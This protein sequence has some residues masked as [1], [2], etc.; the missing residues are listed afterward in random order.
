MTSR[1]SFLGASV[2]R[3]EDDRLL[4]GRGCY[5]ADI[6]LP[7]ML[8][9]AFV[10]SPI[11]HGRIAS[12]DTSTAEK[13]EGVLAARTAE[14]MTDVRPFPDFYEAARPIELFALARHKVRH[15]GA[16]VAVVVANSRYRAEDAAETIS[17]EFDPLPAVTS[18]QQALEPAAPKLFDKWSDNKL[19]SV[20]T[21]EAEVDTEFNRCRT[22]SGH[23]KIQRHSGVPMETRGVVAEYRDG[24]LTVWTSTQFPHIARTMLSYTLPIDE[25][26]IRVVVPDVGGGFGV[27]AEFYREEVVVPWLA[28]NLGCPVRWIEDRHEHLISACHARDVVIDIEA[29]I[30]EDG[31]FM[32]LRGTVVQDLGSGEMFPGGFP[33]SFCTV[34]HLTGPY[35]IPHQAVGVE[36]VVTNKTPSGAYRGFG[37]GEAAFATERLMDKAAAE[38]GLDRNEIRRRNLLEESDLPYTTP[39]GSV[40]DSGS[41]REA[42]EHIVNTTSERLAYWKKL[43][44]SDP[45]LRV[46]SGIANY[47]EGVTPSYFPTTGHWS[48]HDACSITVAPNGT[49]TIAVGVSTSG[50]GLESMLMAIAAEELGAR[51]EQIRIMMGDTDRTPYG[52]GSW[53][54]RS[55]NVASGALHKAATQVVDKAKLIAAHLLEASPADVE[56]DN[57]EFAVR[58]SPGSTVSWHQVATTAY[59]RSVDMPPGIDPGLDAVAS[60]DPPGIAHEPDEHGRFNGSATYTNAS[61]AAIVTVDVGTGKVEVVEYLVAHDCGTVINPLIVKGQIEGGVAQGI[62]GA[63]YESFHYDEFGNPLAASFLDYHIPTAVEIPRMRIEHFESPAPEMPWGAKGAGEAGIIG[64]A[65]AIAA[66]VENALVAMDIPEISQTPISAPLISGMIRNVGTE[67]G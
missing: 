4:T 14:D 54:S 50:Q 58:G 62:G 16:P 23:Y 29:A 67:L 40:I 43:L 2:S 46:G 38:L 31:R 53:G 44:G 18:V 56:V 64:P 55:T 3:I 6:A 63:L 60:Y 52:L 7:G 19:I 39:S 61:H 11:A 47:V 28:M 13:M 33:P 32:A 15:V 51:P 57:G 12:I 5:V 42:F 24:R 41:H 36:G 48:A 65:P 59:I 35:R 8:D 27:K 21:S 49:I 25:A 37:I 45:Q 30:Q 9:A 22:I 34:A 66:A 20:S 17:V 26:D 10:R 1:P